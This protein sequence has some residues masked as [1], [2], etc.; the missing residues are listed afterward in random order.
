M[1]RESAT[2][3]QAV[4]RAL[5]ILTSFTAEQPEL[6]TSE[7]AKISGLGQSTV[8]RLVMTLEALGFLC[9]DERSGLYRLGPVPVTLA[10]TALN[11]SRLY[12]E[13]RQIAHGLASTLGLGSNV[14]ERH[15]QS[16]FYLL[17]FDGHL[18]PRNFTLMGRSGPLHATA[19][20]KA[21]VCELPA[22]ALAAV[23]A[24][25]TLHGY[26]SN[27]ITEPDAFT[28][29]LAVVRKRGYATEIEELAWGRA[30]IAAPIRDQSG[31]I[32]AAISLSGPLS[33]IDLPRRE[34]ELVTKIIEAADRVSSGLGHLDVASVPA[35]G[36]GASLG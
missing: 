22:E 18:A 29:E 9:R 13:S 36:R 2:G 19:M 35:A 23:V 33:A 32:V 12:R 25:K 6:R 14:T 15:G 34:G 31:Q 21:L 27:T 7:L 4:E 20:G 5:H 17:N 30:C 26:T 3:T 24:P 1:S 11:Q 8:S 16:L 10:G 28:D